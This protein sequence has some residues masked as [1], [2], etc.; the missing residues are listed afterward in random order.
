MINKIGFN[1]WI[2]MILDL[3][4]SFHRGESESN[5]SFIIFA[6]VKKFFNTQN[7]YIC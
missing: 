7:F 4:E 2:S 1:D 6:F 3:L 5:I